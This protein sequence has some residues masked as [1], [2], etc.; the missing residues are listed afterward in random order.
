MIRTTEIRSIAALRQFA[1][2]GFTPSR[3]YNPNKNHEGEAARI[4]ACKDTNLDA[5]FIPFSRRSRQG[6]REAQTIKEENKSFTV[7]DTRRE[8]IFTVQEHRV[9]LQF[10]A[11]EGAR[12][13]L[14]F[15]L[16]KYTT[17]RL[18][19]P[20]VRSFLLPFP[21]V[22]FIARNIRFHSTSCKHGRHLRPGISDDI[23]SFFMSL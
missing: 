14:L 21:R 23:C 20:T 18:R 10:R 2:G 15:L 8:R 3:R 1:R 7:G 19:S 13:I 22:Y 12:V 9:F 5:Q 16:I 11:R 4:C 6:G 17:L